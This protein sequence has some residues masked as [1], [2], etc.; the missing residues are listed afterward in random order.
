VVSNLAEVLK[1]VGNRP[2][3]VA[4]GGHNHA[5][6]QTWF[7]TEGKA[8]TRFE[9]TA[10][11]VGPGGDSWLRMAS[12]VTVYRVKGGVLSDG[13]FVRLDPQSR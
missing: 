1:V 5:R 12:G 3:P 10:A 4:L 11:V 9:Q 8:P 7:G 6:E 2:F 13:V